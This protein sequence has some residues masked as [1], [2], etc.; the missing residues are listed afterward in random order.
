MS[1]LKRQTPQLAEIPAASA[2]VHTA[3]QTLRDL[4]GPSALPL[5]GNALQIKIDTIHRTLE[6]WAAKYG[7][8]YK[9]HLGPK[10]V[11]VISD[12][13]LND[14]ILRARPNRFRRIGAIESIFKEMGMHGVFSAEGEEW[15]HQRKLAMQ[16]LSTKYLRN[17]Y[18]TLAKVIE[19]LQ[20]RWSKAAQMDTTFDVQKD[21]MRMTVDVTTNL[22]FGYDMNTLENDGDVIQGHLERIFPA[23]AQRV[24][25]PV[26]YWRYLKL[27]ADHKLDHSLAAIHK[28]VQSFI[29]E[30][31]QRMARE[32]QRLAEPQNFLEAMLALAAEDDQHFTDEEIAGNVF[33]MLVAGEDTTAN[34][35]TWML[36]YMCRHPEIQSRMQREIDAVLGD[37]ERLPTLQDAEKLHFIEAVA[38]ETMRLRPVAPLIFLEANEEVLIG[39]LQLP[40]GT[41]LF[42]ATLPGAVD[43]QNFSDANT[44][45]PERWLQPKTATSGC[46]FHQTADESTTKLSN[47][48]RNAHIPFGHGPRLCPG[49]TLAFVEIKLAMAMLCRHFTVSADSDLDA[50][51][52]I[53]AFAMMPNGLHVRLTPRA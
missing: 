44:F 42:L 7:P 2:T 1:L 12:V 13:M 22:A 27:P 20:N 15:K 28:A 45:R 16:A 50:V 11:V 34:T 23:L 10:P 30:A 9:F 17:F 8:I 38:E 40:A 41:T 19:R 5:L 33:T 14:Q 43:E 49:R 51:E 52:E 46:P 37:E 48:N 39:N 53:W 3:P 4:P 47:H 24:N 31:R 18:P 29:N 36:Y 35:L 25:A 21:F 32:P 26:P 6:Q